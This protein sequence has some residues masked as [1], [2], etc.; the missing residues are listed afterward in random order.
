M[1]KKETV[2]P[3]TTEGREW[4]TCLGEKMSKGRNR[5]VGDLE[6]TILVPAPG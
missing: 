6:R 3:K 2:E 5:E 1:R 4:M